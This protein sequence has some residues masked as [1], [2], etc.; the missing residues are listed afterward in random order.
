V[1]EGNIIHRIVV[2]IGRLRWTIRV[3]AGFFSIF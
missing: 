1:G 2:S 3:F